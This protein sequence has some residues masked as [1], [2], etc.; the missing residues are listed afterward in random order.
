MSELSLS[1]TGDL[2]DL[3]DTVTDRVNVVDIYITDNLYRRLP[4]FKQNQKILILYAEKDINLHRKEYVTYH[5]EDQILLSK[6]LYN[7]STSSDF[8]LKRGIK[9]SANFIGSRQKERITISFNNYTNFRQK[10]HADTELLTIRFVTHSF[11]NFKIK[12][13]L[14]FRFYKNDR[15]AIAKTG[16]TQSSKSNSEKGE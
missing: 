3:E 6:Y 14:D 9:V 13:D 10:I 8:L 12:S 4:T 1:N 2:L 7:F 11:V 5:T 16:Q 15:T